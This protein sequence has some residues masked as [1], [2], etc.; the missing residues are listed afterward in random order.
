VC[1]Q[2]ASCDRGL[3]NRPEV[4]GSRGQH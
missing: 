1:I 3:E 4:E 2:A